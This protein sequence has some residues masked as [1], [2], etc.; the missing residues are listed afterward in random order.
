[1]KDMIFTFPLFG[2]WRRFFTQALRCKGCQTQSKND[3]GQS[4]LSVG[5]AL[6][7]DQADSAVLAEKSSL[8][9]DPS[10]VSSTTQVISQKPF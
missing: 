8:G 1:M 7:S 2:V 6:V 4:D 10:S 9:D 3:P 5:G